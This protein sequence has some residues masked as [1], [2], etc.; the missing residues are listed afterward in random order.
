MTE[1]PEVEAVAGLVKAIKKSSRGWLEA[2]IAVSEDGTPIV[3]ENDSIMID[4]EY[5]A[6]AV[7]AICG[8]I[9]SVMELVN[10]K[11]YKRVSIELE[12]GR[13]VL[14]RKYKKYYVVCLTSTNPNLGFVDMLLEAHLSE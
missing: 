2:V 9:S 4:P 14:I 12:D 6:T 13:K 7:A 10:S 11:D 8:V 3:Y 1:K 5:I